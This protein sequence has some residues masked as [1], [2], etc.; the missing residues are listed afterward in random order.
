M[1]KLVN[2]FNQIKKEILYIINDKDIIFSDNYFICLNELFK[3]LQKT[4][5]KIQ[6]IY[7][8]YILYPN[9]QKKK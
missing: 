2:I 7:Y 1:N 8:K 4:L 9:L 6:N 3:L 5:C